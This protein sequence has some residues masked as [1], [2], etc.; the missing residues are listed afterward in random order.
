MYCTYVYILYKVSKM[1]WAVPVRITAVLLSVWLFPQQV[2][3]RSHTC[4]HSRSLTLAAAARQQL[5]YEES[6]R[7]GEWEAIIGTA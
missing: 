5:G 2:S 7:P 1:G 3:R 4:A 6:V